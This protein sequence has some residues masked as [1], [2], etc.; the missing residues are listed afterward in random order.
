MGVIPLVE[1]LM[2]KTRMTNRDIL[3]T[4]IN[5]ETVQIQ[6]ISETGYRLVSTMAELAPP[7]EIPKQSNYFPSGD[8]WV[9]DDVPDDPDYEY[10]C[11]LY[12]TYVNHVSM[13]TSTMALRYVIEHGVVDEP[14]QEEQDDIQCGLYEVED[15]HIKVE[16]ILD[17]CKST[18]EF[19]DFIDSIVGI[20]MP[21]ESGV[22]FVM[23][24]FQSI[25]IDNGELVPLLEWKSR[26]ERK[27]G[28]V[29]SLFAEGLMACA[30]L[31]GIISLKEYLGLPGDPRY[32]VDG[33][34][35][36]LS[37]CHIIGMNRAKAK[38]SNATQEIELEKDDDSNKKFNDGYD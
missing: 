33:S 2:M 14:T 16:W 3:Y 38:S 25:I 21:T 13:V 7:P 6:P 28:V 8:F 34:P 9:V 37:K 24:S 20:N 19:T 22:D 1:M 5:G 30:E 4:F 18:D 15:D 36:P 35:F 32:V 27:G 31:N 26:K 11:E 12:Q 23:R 10:A 17:K 29:M